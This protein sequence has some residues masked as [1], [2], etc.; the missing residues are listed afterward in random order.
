L[1][2][3]IKL[4]EIT[5]FTVH[6][7]GRKMKTSKSG[8]ALEVEVPGYALRFPRLVRFRDD[9]KSDDATSLK[10]VEEMFKRQSR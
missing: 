7:G 1:A 9:K 3:G 5:R 4:D 8:S 6:T 10:E 2:V